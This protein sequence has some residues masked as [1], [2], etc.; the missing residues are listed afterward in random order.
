[1]S[2]YLK[3]LVDSSRFTLFDLIA[4]LK[5]LIMPSCTPLWVPVNSL[6][7]FLP[8][9]FTEASCIPHA[10]IFLFPRA[11]F[12]DQVC[13]HSTFS[14]WWSHLLSQLYYS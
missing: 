1:M 3:N 2:Y 6:W 11:P 7:P 8:H 4:I 9:F 13:P 14:F 12:L 5:L 10:L